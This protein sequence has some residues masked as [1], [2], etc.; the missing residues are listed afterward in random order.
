MVHGFDF[1]DK[2]A[3]VVSQNVNGTDK[4]RQLDAAQG[5]RPRT[6]L[7]ASTRSA[8][9]DHQL[10]TGSLCAVSQSGFV[11]LEVL[12]GGVVLSIAILGIALMLS[13]G[14]SYVVADGDDRVAL[15]LARQKI[16]A[17]KNLGF[18]CIPLAAT[19]GSPGVPQAALTGC[20]DTGE[21]Q[22]ARTYNE[23]ALAAPYAARYTSRI[24]LVL[25]ADPSTLLPQDPCP[26]HP[27]GKLI[28]VE[29]TPQM[30]QARAIRVET[31]TT[32]H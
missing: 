10:R 26:S 28:R 18:G 22:S 16:E 15:A 2:P 14:Q 20:P 19:A 1:W 8:V 31:T 25:C 3:R 11:L 23:T 32:V 6:L 30:A 12:I 27:V 13:E 7:M 21:T 4:A 29:L 17:V 24:T 9:V 5:R